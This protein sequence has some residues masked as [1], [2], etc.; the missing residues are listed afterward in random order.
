MIEGLPTIGRA[1]AVFSTTTAVPFPMAAPRPRFLGSICCDSAADSRRFLVS[2]WFPEID[3][4]LFAAKSHF[5]YFGHVTFHSWVVAN[6][7]M[8]PF[9]VTVPP[10]LEGLLTKC[11]AR[12]GRYMLRGI[13]AN[14][15]SRR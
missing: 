3:R 7:S 11:W 14:Y 2:V 10:T 15:R 6:T 9:V 5:F 12:G 8:L 13:H 1:S 4:A